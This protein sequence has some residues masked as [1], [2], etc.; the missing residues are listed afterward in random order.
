MQDKDPAPAPEAGSHKH[1]EPV[2][3]LCKVHHS[4]PDE[5]ASG[6]LPAESECFFMAFKSAT[7]D[8]RPKV[9]SQFREREAYKALELEGLT[10]LPP[11]LG[12]GLY[13]HQSSQQWH[14]VYGPNSQYNTA[15]TWNTELRSE[16]KAILIAMCAMWRW[17]C[18]TSKR[19]PDQKY[20]IVLERKLESVKF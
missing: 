9:P 20:L 7:D 15:P 6:S 14:S 18:Q 2:V 19:P 1:P 10:D 12:C 16:E 17:Y 3:S 11:V 8:V 4:G 13:Y 5:F